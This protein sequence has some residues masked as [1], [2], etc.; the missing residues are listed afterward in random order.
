ME[1]D[2]NLLDD[3]E[4]E[5]DIENYNKTKKFFRVNAKT[6]FLTYP[7]CPIDELTF[8]NIMQGMIQQKNRNI[9]L[10]VCSSEYHNQTEGKHIHIYFELDKKIH[11]RDAAFF[12]VI[13]DDSH[14]YHPNIQKPKNKVKIIKYVSG[15]TKKKI[16]D[17]KHVY[18]F[19]IDV[20]KYLY[21]K[22][23]HMK[24]IYEDLIQKK[25]KLTEAVK[26][27]PPIIVQY[28]KMKKNLESYW[29][30]ASI[31]DFKS[32]RLCYWIYGPP[33]IGKSYSIRNTFNNIYIKESN[34][35]WDGYINEKIVLIDDFDSPTLSHYIKIWADNYKFIGEIKGGVVDC[36]YNV[37]FITSNYTIEEIFYDKNNKNSFLL[38]NAIKRRFDVINALSYIDKNNFFFLNEN[39]ISQ[40]RNNI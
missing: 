13:D 6:F 32:K 34:K 2:A 11:I 5:D 40:V 33:G 21:R 8:F 3:I 20:K 4:F 38:I 1:N 19:N 31:L 17:E 27:E 14:V 23:K 36:M 10:A 15:L 12:D 22:L 25:I 29:A 28:T 35:W 39:I 7:Q 30:D 9:K 24:Y 26:V 16:N 37:L 18:E